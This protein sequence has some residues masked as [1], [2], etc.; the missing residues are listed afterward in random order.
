MQAVAALSVRHVSYTYRGRRGLDDVS[1][2]I[3]QGSFA[4]LLGP[5]GAGKTTLVSLITR[6]YDPES[7]SIEVL[8]HS[9]RKRPLAALAM[10]GIV[11]QQLTLDLDLTLRENLRYHC[12]LRGLPR[13]DAEARL[14]D[15]LARARLSDRADDMVRNLSGG[16]RR[17]VEI[18]RALLHRPS[19]LLVDEPTAGLD[20]E[21]RRAILAHAHD[22]C[23]SRGMAVLWATHFMDEAEGADLRL[24]LEAGRLAGCRPV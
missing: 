22:L 24:S 1:F 17:R 5:N 12:A 9:L 14:C 10:M 13:Q 20:V 8:G 21:S 3:P 6:L 23:R 2:S 19:L 7:G 16:L 11:F 18:A 4:V 15:E